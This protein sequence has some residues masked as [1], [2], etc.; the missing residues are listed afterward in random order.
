MAQPEEKRVLSYLFKIAYLC[1]QGYKSWI[2][3]G[4]SSGSSY[5]KAPQHKGFFYLS[6]KQSTLP[7]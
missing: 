7:G 1:Q 2:K 5:Q 4:K 3:T 6:E